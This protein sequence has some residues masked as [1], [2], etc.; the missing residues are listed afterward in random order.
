MRRK[1][2]SR[3]ERTRDSLH[4]RLPRRRSSPRHR[5]LLVV[6]RLGEPNADDRARALRLCGDPFDSLRRNAPGGGQGGPLLRVRVG[7]EVR[8]EEDRVPLL[9]WP[10]LERQRDEVPEAAARHRVLTREEPV[11]RVH[12]Q[13]VT[14][15]HR[16]RDHVAAHL[17][18]GGRRHRLQ[19]EEPHVRPVPR[20]RPLDQCGQAKPSRSFSERPH[21]LLPCALVEVYGEEPA[22]LVREHRVDAHHMLAAQMPQHRSVIHGS[23]RLVRA[24][25]ALYLWQLAHTLDELV[26]AGGRVPWLAR[27]LA[28]ESGRV[29]VVATAKEQAEKLH[30][31]A[32]GPWCSGDPFGGL[33]VVD[34]RFVESG[35]PRAE[36]LH[37]RSRLGTFGIEPMEP[38]F[39]LGEGSRESLSLRR[40]RLAHAPVYDWLGS[41]WSLQRSKKPRRRSCR[42]RSASNRLANAA[43]APSRFARSR[44][45]IASLTAAS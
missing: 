8:V 10:V 39:L 12:A 5:R 36:R 40:A 13:L 22:G 37:P 33:H 42:L 23:E 9:P 6:D 41:F 11:V 1:A 35:Y 28:H 21:I 25:P 19:E 30:L 45:S 3:G 26:R 16:L 2:D 4:A 20:P 44:R 32:R 15:R 17:A 31:L 14:R 7:V 24:V 34:G 43:T 27:L 29:E 38:R 18:G